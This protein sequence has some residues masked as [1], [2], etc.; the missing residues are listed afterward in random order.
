M[1]KVKFCSNPVYSAVIQYGHVDEERDLTWRLRLSID[2]QKDVYGTAET[3]ET[4]SEEL[5]IDCN[6][7]TIEVYVVGKYELS[8]YTV[9]LPSLR[10]ER[11]IQSRLR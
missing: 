11:A 6:D 9:E 5:V 1:R 3:F 4:D 10:S 8:Q 7:E 2:G